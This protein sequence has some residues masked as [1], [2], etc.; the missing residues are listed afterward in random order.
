MLTHKFPYI[1]VLG[2]YF[3]CFGSLMGHYFTKNVSLLGPYLKAWGSLL[4]LDA[5][6]LMK[7]IGEFDAVFRLQAC[8]IFFKMAVKIMRISLCGATETSA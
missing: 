8:S 4:V 6:L 1:V 5:V 7:E 2:P 3:G